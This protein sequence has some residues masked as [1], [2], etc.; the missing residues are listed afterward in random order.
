M[1]SQWESYYV[2]KEHPSGR[3]WLRQVDVELNPLFY[4]DGPL[5]PERYR[6]WLGDNAVGWVA[7]PDAPIGYGG[8]DEVELI[9]KRRP[10]YLR[11]VERTDHWTIYEVATPHPL[12]VPEGG[13]DIEATSLRPDEVRFDVHR[14]GS[15]IVRVHFSPYWRVADGPG[16]VEKAGDWTR[17]TAERPGRLRLV[18]AFAPGRIV[19]RGR[20]CSD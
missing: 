4:D 7:I 20:R 5:D 11:E 6:R 16:C 17:V 2:A 10:P 13:A 9:E 19:D 1:R 3:G 15:V 14:P 18:T 12:A 8:D